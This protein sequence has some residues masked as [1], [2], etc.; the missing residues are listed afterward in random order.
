M[1]DGKSIGVVVPA[2]NE[3]GFVGTV[4]DTLPSYVDRAYV[5]D[6]RSADGT[7]D[8]IERHAAKANE[9]RSAGAVA[10]GGSEVDRVIEPIRHEENRGVGGAITTGYRRALED[11]ID[12]TA[13]MNGDGQMDPAILDEIIGPIVDEEA[14]YV[15]GN[16]LLHPAHREGM[17]RFRF[18]GNVVLTLLTK[19]ASGYW[20]MGDPQNGYTAISRRALRSLDLDGLYEEYGFLNDLLVKLNAREMRVADVAMRATYG[21]ETSTI[22]YRRFVPR[23]SWLLFEDFLWRLKIKYVVFDFHPLVLLYGLGALGF[24]FGITHAAVTA[25]SAGYAGVYAAVA[26]LVLLVS[27][28]FIVLAMVLDRNNNV[29]LE[30]QKYD[31][32]LEGNPE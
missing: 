31:R 17:S 8:E 3:E 28:L 22:R 14:D 29:A 25:I 15:K 2:Y 11:G 13:V 21:E 27:A 16:R 32:V 6:D 9:R 18:V 10:D 24:V 26:V 20:R 1:Y 4:I 23:L 5:V 19:I 12:V 7:W 30:L